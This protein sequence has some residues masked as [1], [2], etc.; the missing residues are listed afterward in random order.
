MQL[1]EDGNPLALPCTPG[2]N[3]RRPWA[4]PGG[5][6]DLAANNNVSKSLETLPGVQ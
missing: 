4:G 1:D 5:Y 2:W 3:V 6:K